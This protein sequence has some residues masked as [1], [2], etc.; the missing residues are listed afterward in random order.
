MALRRATG[1]WF[2]PEASPLFG[3]L[4]L[5]HGSTRGAVVLCPPLGREY[6]GSQAT[7]VRLGARLAELGFAALRLDYR[8]TG[9][10]F[11]RTADSPDEAGFQQDVRCAVDF[12]RKMGPLPIGIVGMRLGA[13]F[14]AAVC[15]VDPVDALV[16]WDPCPTGRSFLREQRALGLIAGVSSAGEGAGT[17]ELPAFILTAEM[18]AEISGL[19]LMAG[20]PGPDE[21][22]QLARKVLV[23]TRSKRVADRRLVAR[24]GRPGVEHREV[25]GQTELLELPPPS[26]KIPADALGTVATWLD[27]VMPR[28]LHPIT[29][30]AGGEVTVPMS[31]EGPAQSPSRGTVP[32]RERAVWLGP[33][34]LFGIETEPETGGH[35]PVCMFVS[36]ANEHRIGPGRIWVQL[37]RRLAVGGFRCVRVDLDGF[38]DSPPR[39]ERGDQPVLSVL[40]IDDVLDTA[41]A[42]SPDD[43]GDVVLIGLSSSGYQV[44]EAA[45]I[46]SPRGV[47]AVNPWLVF[48]PPEMAAG[49]EMD[50]RRRFCLRRTAFVTA[51]REQAP[52]K[53]VG[54]RFPTLSWRLRKPLRKVTWRLR[55]VETSLGNRPGERLGDLA[56]AGTDV[57]LICGSEEIQPF[58]ETGLGAARGAD[59]EG[60]LR[61]EVIP[62]LEHSLLSSKDRDEV[63]AL[64]VDHVFA[65]FRRA[66]TT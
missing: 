33:A 19:D 17:F 64:I 18:A 60:R 40:E 20:Q 14:A 58:T 65:R 62:S 11:D 54:R 47:C 32:V 45:L 44:L 8:S 59:T 29:A 53:W 1:L 61:V 12:V 4:H 66:P 39:A 2:G 22:P 37:S 25:T 30:P 28:D 13:N 52:L 31:S 15:S 21:P 35:G 55:L 26:Q 34:G 3:V 38:G 10:S 43:P 56:G 63:A 48:Q 36:V 50:G 57:L 46:L 16:L 9:D 51:A 23:L 24:L 7:F 27:G 6:A 42:V 41:R 49:A 5:P